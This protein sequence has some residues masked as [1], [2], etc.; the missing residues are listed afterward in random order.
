MS[1]SR[2]RLTAAAVR[3]QASRRSCMRENR[4]EERGA[5][6]SKVMIRRLEPPHDAAS[7]PVR[8]RGGRRRETDGI[9]RR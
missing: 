2:R 6:K 3:A 9:S 4:E 7:S 5:K 8:P 1:R